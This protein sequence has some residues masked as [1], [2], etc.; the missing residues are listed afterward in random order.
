MGASIASLLG[1][2]D[3]ADVALVETVDN[4]AAGS[5]VCVLT[6]DVESIGSVGAALSRIAPA[7]VLMVVAEPPDLAA[8][9]VLGS[10]EFPR[11]RVIALP[12][13]DHG[14]GSTEAGRIAEMIDS[15]VLDRWDV[16]SCLVLCR[17]E[18]GIDDAYAA[19][20][21]RL[22]A[23]GVEEIVGDDVPKDE[24]SSLR[25]SATPTADLPGRPG[26]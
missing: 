17:G 4:R 8:H 6:G 19:V 3:Y 23:R 22:G 14:A 12:G 16:F 25:G 13:G 21:C 26:D 15:I 11:A 20:P 7:A 10:S 18:Y 24:L 2:R 1:D 9:V 5:D